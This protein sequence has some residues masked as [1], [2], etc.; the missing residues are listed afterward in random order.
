MPPDGRRSRRWVLGW[1]DQGR[2]APENLRRAFEVAGALPSPQDWTRFLDRLL[3]WM[4]SVLIAA[5]VIFFFAY[6]WN[7]LGR[8]AKFGLVQLAIVIALAAAGR[9]RLTT[10]A[11]KAALMA[12]A[13]LVGALFAL[14]GQTYQTG[15]DTVELFFVWAVAILPWALLGRLPALWILWIGLVDLALALYFETFGGRL[16]LGVERQLWLL[17]VWNALALTAWETL[18][19]KGV[20]WLDERWA[21]RLLAT[22]VGGIATALALHGI[23]EGGAGAAAWLLWLGAAYGVYRHLLKDLYVLAG[24]VLSITVVVAA[25]LGKHLIDHLAA[26]GFLFVGL[27]VIGVSA[28]GGYWLKTVAREEHT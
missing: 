27:I 20:R 12:A 23:F 2:I 6:N 15:A 22:A 3:L 21:S 26:G 9:F 18:A 4:G 14:I 16:G 7:A 17:L 8:F 10:A 11:G 19:L 1:A 13:L 24:A 25:F 28:A 5:G